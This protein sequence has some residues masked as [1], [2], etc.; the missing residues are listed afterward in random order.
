MNL[1]D[2]PPVSLSLKDEYRQLIED[3][4]RAVSCLGGR[5]HDHLRCAPGCS[6]CCRCFSVAPLEAALIG[7]RLDRASA[8]SRF[9]RIGDACA[10]L[11][12]NLCSVYADRPLIC[13]TQGLPV[14]YID[15]MNEQID[16]S[17][18]PLNFSEDY[19]FS[20][21]DL[22]FL[23]PYNRRLAELNDRYCSK[24]GID[25]GIRISFG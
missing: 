23:D 20:H 1:T 19:Q 5:L 17:I 9:D 24:S 18:C 7:E 14:A 15:E 13:R 4:D 6:S 16:V 22:L 25:G 8:A 12:D 10:F 2:L 11:F 3:V 21:E